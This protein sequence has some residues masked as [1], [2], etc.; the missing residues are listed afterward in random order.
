[1]LPRSF[2]ELLEFFLLSGGVVLVRV[3]GFQLFNGTAHGPG[4]TETELTLRTVSLPPRIARYTPGGSVFL[5]PV[6]L[7]VVRFTSVVIGIKTGIALR[8]ADTAAAD[9]LATISKENNRL[10]SS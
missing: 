10:L 7:L 1:M 9:L 2:K 8:A 3:V 5:V 4:R 6:A